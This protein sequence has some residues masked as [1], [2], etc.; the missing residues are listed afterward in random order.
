MA[1]TTKPASV[2]LALQIGLSVISA[3]SVPHA[4]AQEANE[5]DSPALHALK[6]KSAHDYWCE[7]LYAQ[8]DVAVAISMRTDNG[9][10]LRAK[11][12]LVALIQSTA[13]RAMHFKCDRSGFGEEKA[14]IEQASHMPLDKLEAAM[15]FY[16]NGESE[17]RSK[18]F[19]LLH[20]RQ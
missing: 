5:P 19:S 1:I 9:L 14:H 4:H 2:T 6:L 7:N 13:E 8:H 3:L 17:A 18:Y 20:S 10:D 11:R 12:N 16:S 15:T